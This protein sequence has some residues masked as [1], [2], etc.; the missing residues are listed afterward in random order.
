MFYHRRE[1]IKEKVEEL[2]SKEK[3]SIVVF[4]IGIQKFVEKFTKAWKHKKSK[5]LE[6]GKEIT[7]LMNDGIAVYV[8][9]TNDRIVLHRYKDG[10]FLSRSCKKVPL[11][12]TSNGVWIVGFKDKKEAEEFVGEL[13]EEIKREFDRDFS[14]NYHSLCFEK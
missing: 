5:N 4:S 1:K 10:K 8:N 3:F 9:W 11:W 13:K 6:I 14:I 2:L 12:E 7:G